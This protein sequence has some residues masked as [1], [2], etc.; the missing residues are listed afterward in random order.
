V[1]TLSQRGIFRKD[2]PS[3]HDAGSGAATSYPGCPVGPICRAPRLDARKIHAP[4]PVPRCTGGPP[5]PGVYHDPD[6]EDPPETTSTAVPSSGEP[7]RNCL[8]RLRRANVSRLLSFMRDLFMHGRIIAGVPTCP[9][10]QERQTP[11]Q[12]LPARQ[13][14]RAEYFRR[15]QPLVITRH[16]LAQHAQG[17]NQ[18]AGKNGSLCCAF[19]PV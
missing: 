13:P 15:S 5:P 14:G 3:N 16:R 1:V 8:A 10:P 17:E 4:T 9:R 11:F 2:A 19:Q 6:L 7:W 18:L 12:P